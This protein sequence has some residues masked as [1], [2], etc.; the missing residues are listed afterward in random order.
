M[1]GKNSWGFDIL[2][3]FKPGYPNFMTKIQI[4]SPESLDFGQY[5]LKTFFPI[6]HAIM[7]IVHDRE[8]D[9][10]LDIIGLFHD[11][12]AFMQHLRKKR[13]LSYKT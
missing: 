3:L 9:K 2:V 6:S 4:K 8:T 11:V 12:M 7:G 1:Y 10:S 5:F 13:I